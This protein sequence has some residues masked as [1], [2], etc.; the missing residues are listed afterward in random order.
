[1]IQSKLMQIGLSLH[2]SFLGLT[3]MIKF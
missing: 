3:P 1:L 2:V